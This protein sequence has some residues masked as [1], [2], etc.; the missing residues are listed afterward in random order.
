M[1]TENHEKK[2]IALDI[3]GVCLNLHHDQTFEY[4]GITPDDLTPEFIN[5]AAMYE[6]GHIDTGKFVET[7]SGMLNNGMTETEIIHGWNMII[8]NEIDGMPELLQELTASG[9]RLVFFS[10]TN[11]SHILEMYRKLPFTRF[12][13]GAVYSYETGQVKPEEAMYAAF[14]K[15]YGTPCLYIDDM[16]KNVSAG[17]R[18]GWN[19][20]L[21]TGVEDLR[22]KLQQMEFTD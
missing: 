12:I 13:S 20:I 5:A 14:E 3:G 1:T 10:N 6:R 2:I 16:E 17:L 21:F 15:S 7:I 4:F 18:K 19:S 9:F 8:G 11:E 22:S